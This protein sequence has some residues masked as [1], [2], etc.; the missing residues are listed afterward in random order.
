M[1]RIDRL[2]NPQRCSELLSI[3]P[4]CDIGSRLEP[5]APVFGNIK[6]LKYGRKTIVFFQAENGDE[7]YGVIPGYQA[8]ELK[9]TKAGIQQVRV[10]RIPPGRHKEIGRLLRRRLRGPLNFW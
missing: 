8:S 1:P 9:I 5:S 7:R 4:L 10:D 6:T 3:T 2:S